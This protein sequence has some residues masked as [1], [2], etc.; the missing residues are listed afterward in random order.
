MAVSILMPIYN[1]VEYIDMS[2]NS[3]LNQTYKDWELLIGMNGIENINDK[4]RIALYARRYKN[5]FI[6]D[7][8]IKSKSKTLNKL[9]IDTKYDYIA[10]LDVDDYWSPLKLEKQVK[11]LNY[12]VV[13]THCKYFGEKNHHPAIPV[14]EISRDQFVINPII[15]SSVVMKKELAFW[16]GDVLEDYRLWLKLINAGKKFYNVDEVLTYHRIHKNSYFNNQDQTNELKKLHKE[17]L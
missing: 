8:F 11:Y 17:Y 12:D 7:Y 1:G 15:N 4:N 10:L 5:I 16:E 6:F 14:G 13:G 2:I 9:V 3:I